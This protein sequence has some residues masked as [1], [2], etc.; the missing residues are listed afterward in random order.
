MAGVKG[1]SG[2]KCW[3]KEIAA[4]ELWNLAIPVLKQALNS[5]TIDKNKKVDIALALV[6][7]MLPQELKGE[8]FK[9]DVIIQ[10]IKPTAESSDTGRRIPEIRTSV[11][12]ANQALG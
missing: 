12:E 3:D 11:A 7:K 10:I 6:N 4:R 2:R 5:T 8:G 1:R 9:S